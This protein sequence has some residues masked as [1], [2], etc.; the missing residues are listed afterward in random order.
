M[1]RHGSAQPQGVRSSRRLQGLFHGPRGTHRSLDRQVRS[2]DRAAGQ[3][4][5]ACRLQTGLRGRAIINQ[6]R[7]PARGRPGTRPIVQTRVGEPGRSGA[8]MPIWRSQR[9]QGYCMY[10]DRPT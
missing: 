1:E 7:R 3:R 2:A 6:T 10:G 8:G 4:F 5:E 9:L